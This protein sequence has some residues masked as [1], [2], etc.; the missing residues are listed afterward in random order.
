MSNSHSNREGETMSN[1]G[2][3]HILVFPY[4][5]QGHMLPLLDFTHQLA[6]R[7]LTITIL[8]TPKN[9]HILNPLLSNHPSIHTLVLPF[10]THPSIPVGAENAK[11]VPSTAFL[12]MI[13]AFAR[14]YDP[15]LHWFQSHPSPPVAI[16]SDLFL[17]WT[18]H[19][20]S[21]LGIPC[22][23]FSPAGAMSVSV[24]RSLWRDL[25]QR[26]DPNDPCFPI[27]FP[28]L[29]TSPTFP[30][31]QLTLFYH[32][33]ISGDPDSEFLRKTCL[34]NIASWGIVLNS[35]TA[36][37]SVYLIHMR[38]DLPHQRV[39]AVG[40]LLPPGPGDNPSGLTETERGGSNSVAAGDVLSW[41]DLCTDRSVIYV[42]FGNR[43]SVC[44]DQ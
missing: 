5:A 21:Q 1:S 40:P 8:V 32:S 19:L 29:P 31:W 18:H 20:A 14:L 37:E 4:P 43:E 24:A 36:L 7:G 33:Y 26:D 2:G 34:A 28:K 25:P 30:W 3:E 22:I 35:F 9:L 42:C 38:N 44:V 12:P 41:L 10:P 39:W 23:V 11:D 13:C 27:S 17:G 6:L 15:L 16:I